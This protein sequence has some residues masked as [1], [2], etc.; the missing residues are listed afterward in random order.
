MPHCALLAPALLGMVSLLPAAAFASPHDMIVG[1][2]EKAVW[3]P[4]GVPISG[5]PGKDSVLVM[6]ITDPLHPSVRASLPLENSV[7]GPPTNLQITP[8]GRLALVA[9]SMEDTRTTDS[10]WKAVPTDKLHVIDLATTPPALVGTI[11]VGKQ[12]SGLAINAAGTLALVANRAGKSVSVLTID[13]TTV[14]QVAEV[15]MGN[16]VAAVA[17]TPDGKR[18]FAAMNLANKVAVLSIDG[19]NVTTDKAQDVPVGTGVYNVEVTPDGK[20]AITV[21]EGVAGDGSSKTL[22]VIDAAANPPRR[23]NSVSVGDGPEG[24]AIS[25]D[26]KWVAVPLLLGTTASQKAWS[27]T[28]GGAALLLAIEP[29]GVLRPVSSRPLGA[30][31]EGVVWSPDSSTVY[32]GNYADR[33]MQIFRVQDGKLVEAGQAMKLPGQPASMRGLAR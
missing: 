22:S 21:D 12:P 5:A 33:T 2:D 17:I 30:I 14:K 1:I 9:D 13:G 4:E 20:Y 25:P 6:D 32:I 16:E 8:D 18:A 19:T 11:T 10:V 26:G 28:K 23:V 24:M 15:P 27:Y 29:G 3:G 7:F 31:P